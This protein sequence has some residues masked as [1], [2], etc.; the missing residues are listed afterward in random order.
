MPELPD[1]ETFKRYLDATALHQTIDSVSVKATDLLKDLAVRHLQHCLEKRQ[2]KET[3]R[4]G[5]Y[6][7]VSLDDGDW[8]VLHFGMTG[9]LQYFKHRKDSPPETGLLIGFQ[10]GYYLNFKN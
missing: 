3:Q 4:H 8:L 2:L 7:F 5:K 6:L 1:V 10:N 9:Y